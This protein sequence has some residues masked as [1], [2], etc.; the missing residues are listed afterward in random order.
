MNPKDL[1]IRRPLA[2]YKDSNTWKDLNLKYILRAYRDYYLLQDRALLDEIWPT[3]PVALR[4]IQQFDTDHDGLLDH[5]GADQTYD[6]WLMVGASA[7]TGGLL[8]AAL[9]AA[10]ALAHIQGDAARE[11]EYASW[12]SEA[13]SSFEAKLWNGRYY[14]FNTANRATRESIMADQL[15]GQ[16]YAGATGL[17]D[18]APK[19]HI[20]SAFQVIYEYNV[21][22]FADGQM[23]AV[24]GMRPN[25]IIDTTSDQ[26][27]EV[28]SGV[29][30][31]L[32]VFA[33]RLASGFKIRDSKIIAIGISS[34]IANTSSS[35]GVI[36]TPACP[37][38]NSCN[39]PGLMK[40]KMSAKTMLNMTTTQS[41]ETLVLMS[42]LMSTLLIT[43]SR[44]RR[45]EPIGRIQGA[46]GVHL[47]LL[48]PSCPLMS[49][50][51]A[52][53]GVHRNSTMPSQMNH[54]I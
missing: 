26:S 7:Y 9:E 49:A 31:A 36:C 41:V 33:Q 47:A 3:I 8:L 39:A 30:Y 17:P 52:A 20:D 5:T 28:W 50:S 40:V 53:P 21:R 13:Q 15:A 35:P 23:G 2:S 14:R 44:L 16:W 38:H 48:A 37:A 29:T 6:T 34:S 43:A 42:S 11:Q 22:Q 51:V 1:L 4:Y 18:I 27:Q 54:S 25:G 12:L 46:F 32:S 10:Q 24:N 45:D 19:D